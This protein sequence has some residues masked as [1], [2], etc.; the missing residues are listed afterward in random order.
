MH[1]EPAEDWPDAPLTRAQARD[2]LGGEVVA[3][4]I[5]DYEENTR[6]VLLDAD[7]PDD[8]VLDVVLE[9]DDR[10]DM[11]SYTD[12]EGEMTWLSFGSERKGTEGGEMMQET[13]E[14]YRLL[15]SEGDD[16]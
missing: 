10:Y 15:V 13:L 6:A 3:V 16:T 12:Y 8:V 1:R 7:T 11:F 2:L 5:M 14:S 9:T 4:W